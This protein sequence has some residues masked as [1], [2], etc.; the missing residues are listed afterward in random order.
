MHVHATVKLWATE[1]LTCAHAYMDWMELTVLE[2]IL[3]Q[4][5]CAPEVRVG[6]SLLFSCFQF[7]DE[8]KGAC[9]LGP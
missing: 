8:A 4:L 5:E 3:A 2:Q 7:G 1:A 6:I 9:L